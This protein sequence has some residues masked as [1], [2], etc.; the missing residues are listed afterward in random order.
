MPTIAPYLRK[1]D[2]ELLEISAPAAGAWLGAAGFTV[3]GLAALA[4]FPDLRLGAGVLLLFAAVF[5]VQGGRIDRLRLMVSEKRWLREVGW[6]PFL[7][8]RQ[9]GFEALRAVVITSTRAGSGSEGAAVA[10][11]PEVPGIAAS[12]LR[13]RRL[14]LELDS[15]VMAPMD[16]AE[17]TATAGAG[18][19][20]LALGFPMGPK[21]AE[22]LSED[23]SERLGL[24]VV[25]ESSGP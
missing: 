17:E 6:G 25:D 11:S 7:R 1:D 16:G 2:G 12:R 8:S 24:P 23:F 9:G 13:S 4:L 19:T 15:R 20:R 5:A 18:T 3:A 22:A 14:F 10:A 21:A